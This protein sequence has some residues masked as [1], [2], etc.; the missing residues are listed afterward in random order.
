MKVL[1]LNGPNQSKDTVFVRSGERF[2]RSVPRKVFK[3]TIISAYPFFLAYSASVLKREGFNPLFLDSIVEDLNL[4]STVEK[5]KD[6]SPDIVVVDTSTPS[7]SMDLQVTK[8]VKEELGITT[9]LVDTHATVFH[10][11]LARKPYVD[12]VIRGEFE[13]TLAELV[14]RLNENKDPRNVLGITYEKRGDVIIT[15]DRP[16]LDDIDSLPYPDRDLIP[17][18]NYKQQQVIKEPYF[19]LLGARGCPYRCVFC[20]WVPVLWWCWVCRFTHCR[21]LC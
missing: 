2:P 3:N 1:L 6:M 14:N 13:I 19:Q 8:A 11:E 15:P 7:I 5:I 12:F 16:L 20:L 18:S 9:I 21:I 4:N 10:E 17:Q